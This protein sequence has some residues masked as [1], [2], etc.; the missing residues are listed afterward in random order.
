MREEAQTARNYIAQL[1]ALVAEIEAMGDQDEVFDTLMCL[2]DDIHEENNKLL[3]LNGVIVQAKERI[4]MKEEHVKVMEAGVK[5]VS[6]VYLN[7]G[8]CKDVLVGNEYEYHGSYLNDCMKVMKGVS[9]DVGM[10]GG[11]VG[12]GVLG[13]WV[14]ESVVQSL[15]CSFGLNRYI[16]TLSFRFWTMDAFLILD[17]LTEIADSSRLQDK[18]KVVFIRARSEDASFIGLMR[19]LCSGLR[20]SLTKNRQL[21]AELEAL[22]QRGDAFRSLD[23]MREMVVRDSATL[24]VLE[25]LL[26]S[27]HVGMCLKAGYVASMYEAE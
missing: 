24:G 22:G 20:L 16:Y 3:E 5:F 14:A 11:Y 10:C 7:D 26:T 6:L 19:E 4:A 21:I 18:I 12:N 17:K 25:Q 27:T 8:Q 15:L 2:R 9:C 23:Y 1:T 13:L